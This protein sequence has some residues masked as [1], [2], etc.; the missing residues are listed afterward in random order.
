MLVFAL[1]GTKLL[2]FIKKIVVPCSTQQPDVAGFCGSPKRLRP[3]ELA[4]LNG[5][6]LDRISE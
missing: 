2:T 1:V 5:V 4:A 6:R 3:L